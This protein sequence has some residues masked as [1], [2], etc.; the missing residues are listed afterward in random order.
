VE[1]EAIEC[2]SEEGI[3][4]GL[5]DSMLAAANALNGRDLSHPGV[6]EALKDLRAS[7]NV[8]V[9]LAK[10]MGISREKLLRCSQIGELE[11]AMLPM[12]CSV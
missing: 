6:V 5:I 1:S 3:T 11:R 2:T 8:Q 4:I 7:R 9:L 10:T 12:G